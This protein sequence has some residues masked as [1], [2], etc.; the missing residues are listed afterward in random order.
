MKKIYL[1]AGARKQLE[2]SDDARVWARP[3][4]Y[5]DKPE[6][7]FTSEV[8][9]TDE[10]LRNYGNPFDDK[11]FYPDRT[12]PDSI[13]E[14]I[15][16]VRI[17]KPK[18]AKAK[19]PVAVDGDVV[20][21]VMNPRYQFQP[22]LYS[23]TSAYLIVGDDNGKAVLN[24]FGE[25]VKSHEDAMKWYADHK[26]RVARV[27]TR[28]QIMGLSQLKE[29]FHLKPLNKVVKELDIELLFSY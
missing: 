8:Y 1:P 4:P 2:T 16:T 17:R 13:V 26:F 9:F 7:G 12:E 20:R 21:P 10:E 3:I 29:R 22:S 28:A 11:L 27:Y 6:P 23:R 19:T 18:T 24:H 15:K 5:K 25:N 14:R